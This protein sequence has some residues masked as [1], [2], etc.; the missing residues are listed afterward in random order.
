MTL[1]DSRR[2]RPKMR[3]HNARTASSSQAPL[4]NSGR[5]QPS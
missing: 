1:I 5:L 4:N 2:L 3:R